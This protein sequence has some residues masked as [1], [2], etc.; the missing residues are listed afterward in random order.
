ML[1]HVAGFTRN[2]FAIKIGSKLYSC[3]LENHAVLCTEESSPDSSASETSSS[4]VIVYTENGSHFSLRVCQPVH[5]SHCLFL[6]MWAGCVRVIM[7]LSTSCSNSCFGRVRLQPTASGCFLSPSS[8]IASPSSL[9]VDGV[10]RITFLTPCPRP[11]VHV[12]AYTGVSTELNVTSA[13]R[14]IENSNIPILCC[15]LWWALLVLEA[16]VF[17][18]FRSHTRRCGGVLL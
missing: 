9:F 13:S 1:S 7:S 12:A 3:V 4:F 15:K 11:Y 2:L 10:M 6:Y 18:S 8:S 17:R 5:C 14:G 16:A